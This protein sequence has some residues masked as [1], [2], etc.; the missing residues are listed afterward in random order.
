MPDYSYEVLDR[1][2]KRDRGMLTANSERD[3]ITQLDARGL[4]PIRIEASRNAAQTKQGGKR[5]KSRL[6][7]QFFSQLADL[8][9]AGVPLLRSL[10]TLERNPA[11]KDV[12][13]E[14][15]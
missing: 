2:G 9:R 10:E 15:R 7:A 11:L 4:Y 13:R 3:A 12:L 1:T 8:L 6:M 5:I 14:V